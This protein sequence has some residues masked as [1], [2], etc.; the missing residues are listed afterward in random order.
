M[1]G[2]ASETAPADALR[3]V[4]RGM[5]GVVVAYSGGVDSA[6]LFRV[7]TQTLG[8]RAVGA[9]GVSA[10]LAPEDLAAA[11]AV[12]TSFGG[13]LREL[14][15]EEF[16]DERYA[17]NPVNRCYF[18]K[19]EL[20]GRL[21]ALAAAEGLPW[22]ADGFQLDDL[23]DVRPGRAAGVERGIR[24]PLAEAGFRKADVRALARALGLPVWDKPAAPC[25][26]S[27]VAF[28]LRVTPEL[29]ARIAEAERRV[30]DLVPGVRDLRVR[31][32]GPAA[33]VELEPERGEAARAAWPAIAAAL[34]E[35]GWADASL[36]DYRRGA[37]NP[38]G[39]VT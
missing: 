13:D 33:R 18:C 32:L 1:D 2:N 25:L 26:S 24:S 16:A 11:R 30:R 15:T 39:A 9:I 19:A 21:A 20:Y 37:L 23:G 8:R 7:A 29:T 6:L 35:L 17:A 5:G 3:A 22:V 27:R 36:A 28:G 38:A 4:L 14:R 31:H 34:R 12:A 10:S